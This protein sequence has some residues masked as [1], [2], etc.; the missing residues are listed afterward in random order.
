MK[1]WFAVAAIAATVAA[2]AAQAKEWKEVRFGVEGA[3]PPFSKTEADGSVSGFDVDI[4]NALCKEMDVKCRLV[5]QDWDGIIPSLLARKYDAIIAAMSI[6]EDRKKK[7]DFTNKYALIPNKFIAKK[8]A[9]LDFNSL[10]GVKIGVQRA[11]THDKYL[12]D[13]Y[14]NVDIV[15][16]GS[17]DEAYLD[18]ANGRISAVLGDASALEGGVLQ[19]SGGENYEFVG[20]SLTD[21]TW[22]GEG[23]GIALR[24]QDKDLTNKIN[25]ALASLRDK[26][27]YQEIQAKYFEY[28]VYGE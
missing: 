22:F 10:D 13:N 5:P 16:Y 4:A 26:G 6:T 9:N 23:F 2:G 1:K 27:V 11:T 17:F 14:D 20:P 3:Y 15:R 12:T 24:K 8:G 7:V 18:L 28:D 25:E 19:K 21:P